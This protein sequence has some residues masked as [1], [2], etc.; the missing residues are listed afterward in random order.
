[1]RPEPGLEG[2]LLEGDGR[3]TVTGDGTI[4]VE[5]LPGGGAHP[6]ATLWLPDVVPAE[7]RMTYDFKA[8]DQVGYNILLVAG[9]GAD[10][11]DV[12]AWS[13]SATWDSYAY[14]GRLRAYT[15]SYSRGPTG[16]SGMRKLWA[17]K[18]DVEKDEM[19]PVVSS[20]ADPC[21]E[22]GLLHHMMLTKEGA[23]IRFEVDGALVHDYTDDGAYGPVLVGGRVG[24]RN[25]AYPKTVEYADIRIEPFAGGS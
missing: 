15:I 8:I 22:P 17:P 5:S 2:W 6:A 11:E 9:Q 3:V 18:G 7:F 25:F 1:L 24:L 21:P 4:R 19:D 23:R 10:G 12:A 20:A 13:R 16:T 14:A